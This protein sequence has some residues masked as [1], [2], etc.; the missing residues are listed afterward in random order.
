M[1]KLNKWRT[2]EVAGLRKKLSTADEQD[3]TVKNNPA[4]T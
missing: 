4:K 2:K 3:L 1:R